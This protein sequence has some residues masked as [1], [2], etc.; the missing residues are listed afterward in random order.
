MDNLNI[1][2]RKSLDRR[3]RHGVGRRSGTAS[4]IHYTPKH[5]SWL[6]QAEIEIG[7]FSRQ[8]LGKR[9]IPSFVLLKQHAQNWNRRRNQK[10]NPINWRFDRKGGPSSIRLHKEPDCPV[11]VL[12]PADG[13]AA[14]R[15]LGLIGEPAVPGRQREA[16]ALTMM[17][18]HCSLL[19]HRPGR[20]G[21]CPTRRP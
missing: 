7:I 21:S 14:I 11:G 17:M 4:P 20:W 2:R 8:C 13:M 10:R 9:R 16:G 6:N 15:G 3:L 12:D 1:H 5:G 18:L 19:R